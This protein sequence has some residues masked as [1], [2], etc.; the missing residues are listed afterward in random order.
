MRRR[1]HA[2]A[3]GV[4]GVLA[5]ARAAPTA[6]VSGDGSSVD[7]RKFIPDAIRG[8]MPPEDGSADG[9]GK[10][11]KSKWKPAPNSTANK[12][13]WIP[14][15]FRK[16]SPPPAPQIPPPAP[17]PPPPPPAS[18]P[19]PTP[20]PGAPPPTPLPRAP[21]PASPP[22]ADT[23]LLQASARVQVRGDGSRSGLSARAASLLPG[24]LII[25][26]GAAIGYAAAKRAAL[27]SRLPQAV[28]DRVSSGGIEGGLARATLL[29][30]SEGLEV[31]DH[32]Q[33]L[34]TD[35]GTPL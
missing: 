28:R 5:L 25:S 32:Y 27:G 29:G 35:R 13:A 30:P 22:P 12:S 4:M 10:G 16:P 34:V 11:K 3:L 7:W 15:P 23:A 1:P 18:T 8:M 6:P 17:A 21:P 20:L 31:A 9:G 14:E 24:V 33:Q 26:A 2:V 19:P